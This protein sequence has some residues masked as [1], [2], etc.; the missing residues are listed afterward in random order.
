MEEYNVSPGV[1]AMDLVLFK[2]ALEHICRIVRV[3]SQPRGNMLLVGIGTW[4]FI[5]FV[6]WKLFQ[7]RPLL[8]SLNHGQIMWWISNE[9]KSKL[10]CQ[11]SRY[12]TNLYRYLFDHINIVDMFLE[13]NE[14][15]TTQYLK[16]E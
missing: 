7:E 9:Y 10:M 15:L 2:D 13:I 14:C 4:V 8:L 1:V 16:H 12:K 6:F 3:I 11:I 5:K